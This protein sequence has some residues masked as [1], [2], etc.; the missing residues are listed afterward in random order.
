MQLELHTSVHLTLTDI[1][2]RLLGLA[3]AGKLTNGDVL[4][5]KRLNTKLQDLR[6][7]QAQEA[8]KK[9]EEA[10]KA[11][12]RMEEDAKSV[13]AE[14]PPAQKL[15]VKPTAPTNPSSK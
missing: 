3:L 11:A 8:V 14:H 15:A 10:A 4:A 2:F 5:A 12:S 9:Y 7:C 13:Q 1:E 6:F